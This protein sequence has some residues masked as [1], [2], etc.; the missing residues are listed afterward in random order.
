MS[1]IIQKSGD[2]PKRSL[3]QKIKDVALMD[4]A[5]IAKGGVRAGS[6]EQLEELLIEADF[7]VPTT[8]KLVADVEELAKR[9]K[10]KTEEEFHEALRSGVEQALLSG[11]SDPRL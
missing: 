1:R 2:V 5:V 10:V 6:L 11:N 9:G 8:L 4:V 3:W 7:G